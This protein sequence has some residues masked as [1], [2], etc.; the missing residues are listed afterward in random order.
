MTTTTPPARRRVVRG[1][2]PSQDRD[3]QGDGHRGQPGDEH[4]RGRRRRRA[5]RSG[6][7][8]DAQ[9]RDG[10]ALGVAQQGDHRD[11]ADGDERPRPPGEACARAATSRATTVSR[12]SSPGQ[13]STST[14]CA[15]GERDE[16]DQ[17]R[18]GP[19]RGDD[20]AAAGGPRREPGGR[21][22]RAGRRSGGRSPD[23]LRRRVGGPVAVLTGLRGLV[24]VAEA[25]HGLEGR[26]VGVVPVELAPQPQHGVLDPVR[27]QAR[28]GRPRPAR[29]AGRP[30]GPARRGGPGRDSSRYSV[31]VSWTGSP[32]RVTWAGRSRCADPPSSKT[33]GGVGGR[34]PA[35][36]DGL[37]AGPAARP[38]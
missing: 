35:A 38:G 1:R 20:R 30:R 5:R 10:P 14:T 12:K 13:A 19:D 16:A 11:V 4:G 22:G 37:A 25:P 9:A 29:S 6:Q 7:E 17:D 24:A 26:V 27:G 15:G 28:R 31:G 33:V 3:D 8:D 34:A 23:E 32:S 21:P 36:P 2:R 18:Q